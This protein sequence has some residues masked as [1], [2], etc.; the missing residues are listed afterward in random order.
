MQEVSHPLTL[1]YR[2]LKPLLGY[3]ECSLTAYGN[4]LPWLIFPL[5][6][7]PPTALADRPTKHS[8]PS[9]VTQNAFS[10]PMETPFLVCLG[11]LLTAYGNTPP[12]M[13]FLSL[14]CPLAASGCLQ[15]PLAALADR[16]I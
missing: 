8:K 5:S 13:T 4:T 7:L 14:G 2:A 1:V 9:Q 3:T 15:L 10:Q 12:W 16:S 11:C 6:R